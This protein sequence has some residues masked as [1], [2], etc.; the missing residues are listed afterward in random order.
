MSDLGACTL[1]VATTLTKCFLTEGT[2]SLKSHTPSVTLLRKQQTSEKLDAAQGTALLPARQNPAM[3]VKRSK[4]GSEPTTEDYSLGLHVFAIFLILT[5]G[6]CAASFPV[7]VKASPRLAASQHALFISRHFGTGVLIALAFAHLLPTAFENLWNECLPYFW[8]ERYDAAPGFIAMVAA[9]AVILVE[10]G[11]SIY[12]IRHT[13]DNA[14]AAEH[15][16]LP[17]GDGFATNQSVSGPAV[18]R[19]NQPGQADSILPDGCTKHSRTMYSVESQGTKNDEPDLE[20]VPLLSYQK[21]QRMVLQCLL[22]EAGIL[23]HSILIGL[24]ISISTGTTFIA[25]IIAIAFH[26]IFEGL[27]LGARIAAIPSLHITSF[28]TWGMSFAVSC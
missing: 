7:L 24:S 28:R 4:C 20:S 12:G 27:A 1:M 2:N 11:F 9:L 22:L 6:T 23:F 10:M 3:I 5:C 16:S 15:G 19:S 14:L 21:E 18:E 13:H 17:Q 26:Q 8:T 25:L